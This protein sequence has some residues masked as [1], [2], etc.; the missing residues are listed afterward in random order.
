MYCLVRSFS[1]GVHNR[2]ANMQEAQTL[3][4]LPHLLFCR[5]RRRCRSCSLAELPTTQLCSYP[6]I[7]PSPSTSSALKSPLVTEQ[8]AAQ[9]ETRTAYY[10]A[11]VQNGNQGACHRGTPIHSGAQTQNSTAPIRIMVC[12][13]ATL[14]HSSA[15]SVPC[16]CERLWLEGSGGQC[17][18]SHIKHSTTGAAGPTTG[19]CLALF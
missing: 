5:Q 9:H 8:A 14:G 2:D 6:G 18:H 7:S 13:G 3:S 17:P 10:A 11:T 1:V 15:M 12:W 16:V 4:M 19:S